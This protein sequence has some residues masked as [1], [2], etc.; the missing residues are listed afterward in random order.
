M[1]LI[2]C[3]SP[4]TALATSTDI[5]ARQRIANRQIGGNDASQLGAELV[6]N[7]ETLLGH[8]MSR[9]RKTKR[10]LQSLDVTLGDK[11]DLVGMLQ[12]LD[13]ASFDGIVS[14]AASRTLALQPSCRRSVAR[15]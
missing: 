5:I 15:H 8:L 2:S 3:C 9:M 7:F 12:R 4:A 6:R 13:L 14:Q 11:K 1:A 10:L